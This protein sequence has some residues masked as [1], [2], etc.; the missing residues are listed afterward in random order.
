MIALQN[1]AA[2]SAGVPTAT[3]TGSNNLRLPPALAF[4][5]GLS[6]LSSQVEAL[7]DMKSAVEGAVPAA[8]EMQLL[9]ELQEKIEVGVGTSVAQMMQ[10]FSGNMNEEGR[11]GRRRE[12]LHLMQYWMLLFDHAMTISTILTPSL[13]RDE[14]IALMGFVE[15]YA[16]SKRDIGLSSKHGIGIGYGNARVNACAEG[17]VIDS[18]RSMLAQN[19]AGCFLTF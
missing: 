12:Y 15:Q 14:T 7:L 6:E 17:K 1:Q 13:D 19:L 8:A 10:L 5:C 16:N 9:P 4:L 18:V 2:A 11:N 3:G